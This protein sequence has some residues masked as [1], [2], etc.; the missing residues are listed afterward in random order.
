MISLLLLLSTLPF[1]SSNLKAQQG[2]PPLLTYNELVEL[3]ENAEPPPPLANKLTRLLTTPFVNNS[4]G[5]RPATKARVT[6]I[7]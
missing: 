3:Y 5:V 4:F 6:T 1:T 7:S 2:N